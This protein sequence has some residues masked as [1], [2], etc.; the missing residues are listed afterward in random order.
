MRDNFK[1]IIFR[2][3][4]SGSASTKSVYYSCYDTGFKYN[5]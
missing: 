2:F 5:K 3:Q 1:K 4:F